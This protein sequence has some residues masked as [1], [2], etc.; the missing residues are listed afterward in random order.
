MNFGIINVNKPPGMTSH[1]VVSFIR[2]IYSERR[3]GHCGTLDPA[4]AGVLP[5]FLGSATRLCEY[6]EGYQKQYRVEMTL[7][8]KTLTGDDTGEIISTCDCPAI[9]VE[10][11]IVLLSSFEGD[12]LQLPP[13]YSALKINGRKLYE[14]AREGVTVERVPRFVH[15][16]KI[17]LISYTEPKLVF[18]VACSKGTYI[19]TLCEEMGDQISCPA[20]MSFLLRTKVG[21]FTIADAFTLEEIAANPSTCISN[22]TLAVQ[23]FRKIFLPRSDILSIL[24]GRP[25]IVTESVIE[26]SDYPICIYDEKGI[27]I[28]IGKSFEDNAG[29]RIQPTKI[30]I[31]RNIY[32]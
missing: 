14:L 1:D 24:Q 30:L 20:V 29:H 4:A 28:G 6:A 27:F 18:D 11:I 32:D 9:T 13:M 31:D 12:R 25:V 16:D 17:S 8:I 15:F 22:P 19:R 10:Q 23:D 5:V 7:G 2:K 26:D 3:V 21:S